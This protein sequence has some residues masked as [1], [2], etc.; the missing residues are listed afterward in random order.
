M[1]VLLSILLCLIC[2]FY[3]LPRRVEEWEESLPVREAQG[4]CPGYWS[5]GGVA[6]GAL[7]STDR[8][9]GHGVQSPW[10]EGIQISPH[11]AT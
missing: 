7:I 8:V 11:H 9:L 10:V 5:R 3:Q 4:I 6:P 2:L 1:L